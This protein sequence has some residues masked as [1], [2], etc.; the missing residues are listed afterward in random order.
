MMCT[1]G[2]LSLAKVFFIPTIYFITPSLESDPSWSWFPKIATQG[3][4]DAI[5]G[6]NA[7]SIDLAE[8][9]ESAPKI[10]SPYGQWRL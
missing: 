3:M 5:A 10:L 7:A 1:S 4:F 8:S 6:A 9:E 2:G